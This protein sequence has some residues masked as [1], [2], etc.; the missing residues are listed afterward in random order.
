MRPVLPLVLLMPWLGAPPAHAQSAEPPPADPRVATLVASISEQRLQDLVATL[1][2]FGT[3]ETLSSPTSLTRGIGAARQWI[4]DDMRRSSPRLEVSFDTYTLAQQG[5]I[6]WPVELR[7]VIAVL[8]GRSARRIYVTGHYDSV[9]LEQQGRTTQTSP[10]FD[11]DLGAPGANDNGSGTALTIELAR[12]FAESGIEFDATLVFACW[13]GE[14]Q[15]LVGSS[16]H[17]QRIS[18]EKIPVDAVINNDIVGNIFDGEGRRD[19]AAVRVFSVGPED[20]MSR[21]LARYIAAQAS[22]YIPS[23]QVRLLAREDRLG[24]GSDHTSFTTAGYAAVVVREAAENRA[25]Q[26]SA[27]D[28]LDGV[29]ASYLARNARVNAAAVASLALAPSAPVITD[30]D[31]RAR[32]SPDGT[33][34]WAPSTG[35]V[36]Y[37]IYWRDTWTY[38]WQHSQTVGDV[39]QF[40][41]RGVPADDVIFGIAAVGRDGHESLIGTY[42]DAPRPRR[43][44]RFTQ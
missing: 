5:R 15:E 39:R 13:A 35:A 9:N 26:H 8:P 23:H 37:R 4:A 43:E 32:I 14:E 22:I 40:I 36:A 27:R 38:D 25:R 7:N 33:L 42:V 24:R 6:T 12:A 29:D 11:H 10:S 2:G 28:T 19:A 16:A 21:S 17:A 41:V 1:T 30:G 34:R 31:G 3:R 20:S 18:G 44:I